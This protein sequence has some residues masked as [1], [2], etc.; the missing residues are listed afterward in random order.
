[1]PSTLDEILTGLVAICTPLAGVNQVYEYPP[2]E[3]P[4]D[5]SVFFMVEDWALSPEPIGLAVVTWRINIYHV[6]KRTRS[7]TNMQI[8]SPYIQ[9]WL[10]TLSTLSTITLSG[11]A[12]YTK[13]DK[14]HIEIYS[15]S[16]QSYMAIV[17]TIEVATQ[18]TLPL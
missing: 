1:M 8:L 7:Q 6:F 11:A 13:P 9:T 4:I 10:S 12:I 3:P 15:H 2:E 17:N 16:G 14:G 18:F 5:S